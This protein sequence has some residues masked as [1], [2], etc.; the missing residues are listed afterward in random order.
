VKQDHKIDILTSSPA[1][2]HPEVLKESAADFENNKKI[3]NAR[4]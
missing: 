2:R 1:A 3:A 4:E